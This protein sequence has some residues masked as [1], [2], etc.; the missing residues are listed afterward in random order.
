M[1][2]I[3]NN[4]FIRLQRWVQGI[5]GGSAHLYDKLAT[6]YLEPSYDHVV[7]ELRDRGFRLGFDSRS[8]LRN[9]KASFEGRREAETHAHHR[10][11]HIA[12]DDKDIQTERV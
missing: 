10:N 12:C 4:I 2:N 5:P 3:L 7:E 8:G 11:R 9:W 1:L 6:R